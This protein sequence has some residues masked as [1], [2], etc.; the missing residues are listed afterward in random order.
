MLSEVEEIAVLVLLVI[1]SNSVSLLKFWL[2]TTVNSC[3]SA[4][5]VMVI[6]NAI[7][8]KMLVNEFIG[9]RR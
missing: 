9:K 6:N 3:A 7:G 5:G 4:I 1:R 2:G 8:I